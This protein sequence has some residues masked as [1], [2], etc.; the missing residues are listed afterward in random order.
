MLNSYQAA[1][2]QALKT[3][4]VDIL[5]EGRIGQV[6]DNSAG[7]PYIWLTDD[8]D[9]WSEKTGNG[10]SVNLEVHIGSRYNGD[11]EVNTISKAV[12]NAL[13]NTDLVLDGALLVLCQFTGST[14]LFDTDGV[15][16]HR[17]VKFNLLVSED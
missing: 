15:T 17:V 9:D 6:A 16:R 2:Y 5:V 12:Y 13:H 7:Y 10:L 8:N 11:K 1:I 3:S 14:Q 4:Q